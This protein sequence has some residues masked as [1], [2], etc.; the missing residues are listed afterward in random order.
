M[1]QLTFAPRHHQL[2]NINVW[3]AD[4]QWLAYDVRPSGASFTGLT[5]ER[6]N[7]ASGATEILYQ[8]RD[9]AHVGVVTVSPDL[10]PRYVCIHGPEHPDA[11]WRYDFHHRRGVIIQNG[12]AENLDACDITPPFTPGALRGG[13]HVHVF[14]PDGSRL[15][16]TYNDHVM[17]EWDRREDLRNV[18][19]AVPLHAVCPVKQHPREYDGSHFCVLVSRTTSA[20]QAG[21]DEINRAYEEGWVGN[22][23]YQRPDGSRQRWALAFIGDTRAQDGTTVPEVYL[24]DLPESLSDYAQPGEAPLEGTAT[25][26]P[27]PPRGVRQRRLTFTHQRRYPGLATAPRHWLRSSPD[28]SEI[29]FLM[30]DDAGVVQLWSISPCGGEPRQITRG[31]GDMQSAFSWHPAGGSL[32]IVCDNSVMLCDSQS[33]EMRRLTPRSAPPPVGDAVVFSPDGRHIAWMSVVD[34]YQQI[35]TVAVD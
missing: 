35:F 21:S 29:A 30:R 32:A 15:S 28:G 13:S 34:G 27:A 31:A 25:Q 18:G 7:V 2:T 23:G 26:L 22:L 19:V 1:K 6:V 17:H 14:S 20:P 33:G 10:P 12:V 4:S 24:V 8:A 9:G 11:S 16:F 3:T 5:I